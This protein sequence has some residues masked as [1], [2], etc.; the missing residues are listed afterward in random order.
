MVPT[1]FT[2]DTNV[3]EIARPSAPK[4]ENSPFLPDD[5]GANVKGAD[6][7][8]ET[9]ISMLFRMVN[10]IPVL[11]FGTGMGHPVSVDIEGSRRLVGVPSAQPRLQ[12]AWIGH[13]H[14]D[15]PSRMAAIPETKMVVLSRVEENTVV[16]PSLTLAPGWKS[17]P[18]MV[19]HAPPCVEPI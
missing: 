9:L 3:P 15:G 12:T 5:A 11:V 1:A 2:G 19:A 4:N 6:V 14:V 13:D 7:P 17:T 16:S 8:H 10:R 18:V